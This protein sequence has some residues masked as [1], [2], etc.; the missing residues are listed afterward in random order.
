LR[1][2]D[3]RVFSVCT[4]C[5]H[6]MQPVGRISSWCPVSVASLTRSTRDERRETRDGRRETGNGKRAARLQ[7]VLGFLTMPKLEASSLKSGEKGLY[8]VLKCVILMVRTLPWCRPIAKSQKNFNQ[9]LQQPLSRASPSFIARARTVSVT[10]RAGPRVSYAESG[11]LHEML[12]LF[13][14]RRKR[15]TAQPETAWPRSTVGLTDVPG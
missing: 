7:K 15:V 4:P 3:C 1:K 8:I 2:L 14:G 6:V 11:L 13:R 5:S 12:L 10:G 9:G